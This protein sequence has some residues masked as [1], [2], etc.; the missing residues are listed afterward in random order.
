MARF[1]LAQEV[2]LA[3]HGSSCSASHF[4]RGLCSV[5]SAFCH[6]GGTGVF[7]KQRGTPLYG[8]ATLS[9]G[10][11]RIVRDHLLNPLQSLRANITLMS[12]WEQGKPFLSGPEARDLA[13]S[14]VS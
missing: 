8:A 11:I 4:L 12:A 14:S 5:R 3:R 9:L 10:P 7:L 6:S 13:R 1:H 2:A